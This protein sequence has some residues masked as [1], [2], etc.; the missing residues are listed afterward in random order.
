ML[1]SSP[2]HPPTPVIH[3]KFVFHETVPGSKKVGDHCPKWYKGF[4]FQIKMCC[5]MAGEL[6]SSYFRAKYGW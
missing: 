6:T 5:L 2:N 3:G 4:T 1:E